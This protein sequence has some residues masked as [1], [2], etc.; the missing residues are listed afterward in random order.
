MVAGKYLTPKISLLINDAIVL[1]LQAENMMNGMC[2]C[3]FCT[4]IVGFSQ[5]LENAFF[6]DLCPC[7]KLYLMDMDTSIGQ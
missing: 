4:N 6:N 7:L 2:I 5:C 3:V 1:S